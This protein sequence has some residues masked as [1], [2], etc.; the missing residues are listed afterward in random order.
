MRKMFMMMIV[1][2][3]MIAFCSCESSSEASHD[4]LDDVYEDTAYEGVGEAGIKDTEVDEAV[5]QGMDA[6]EQLNHK[7][8][9]TS[10][11][12]ED[13][14]I[15][16]PGEII[17]HY[18]DGSTYETTVEELYD[19]FAE[20][21]ESAEEV[22]DVFSLDTIIGYDYIEEI[23]DDGTVILESGVKLEGDLWGSETVDPADLYPG[24]FVEYG[25]DALM[26]PID[27]DFGYVYNGTL[28]GMGM[29]VDWF[30]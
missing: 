24:L 8:S 12:D 7:D 16:F 2:A 19:L 18:S 23:E 14:I 13:G 15:R 22:I 1:I 29:V 9:V 11:E 3:M 4:A 27:D 21:P 25:A 6:A 30:E 26:P 28:I 5:R 20:D 17:C 10:V